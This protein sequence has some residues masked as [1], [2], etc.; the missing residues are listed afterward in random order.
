MKQGEMKAFRRQERLF[1]LLAGIY[2]CSFCSLFGYIVS[3]FLAYGYSEVQCG[4]LT[5][6][7]YAVILVIDPV[8]GYLMDQHIPPKK[9]FIGLLLCS[10]LLNLF[11]PMSLRAGFVPTAI[12]VVFISVF[13][14]SI[15]HVIDAWVN[16]T[17]RKSVV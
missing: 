5:T 13:D 3:I 8:Y 14:L 4:W 9:M 11:L 1:F 15:S 12:M 2:Y 6:I 10:F 16:S 17:D 7:E